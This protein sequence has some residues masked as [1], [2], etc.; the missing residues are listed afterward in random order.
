MIK[1][2]SPYTRKKGDNLKTYKLDS[3]LLEWKKSRKMNKKSF[4]V[5][6]K[7]ICQRK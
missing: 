6:I 5:S 4:A 7:F 1:I 2:F 3:T